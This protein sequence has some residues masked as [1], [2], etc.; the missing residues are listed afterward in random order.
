L[1]VAWVDPSAVVDAVVK[2]K[3]T[4]PYRESDP[5]TPI[6]ENINSLWG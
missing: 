4:G 6:V 1:I 3:I 2:R 5:G